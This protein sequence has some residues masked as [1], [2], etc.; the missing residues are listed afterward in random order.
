MNEVDWTKIRHFKLHEFA[1]PC[2]CGYNGPH[3]QLVVALDMA[4]EKLGRPMSISSGCRCPAHNQEVGGVDSSAHV[5]GYAVDIVCHTSGERF[6][7]FRVLLQFF[8][9]IGVADS[10][11]HVDCDPDKP[12]RVLW[13]Y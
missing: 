5:G 11:V 13:T 8:D 6:E 12:S 9:R 10:F 4:R 7:L 3:P 2:G 1:C